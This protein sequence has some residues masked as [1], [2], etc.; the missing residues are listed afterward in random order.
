[1]SVTKGVG[2]RQFSDEF[3]RLVVSEVCS[4]ESVASVSKR[5]RVEGK[6]IRLWLSDGRYS[7]ACDENTVLHSARD[8][9]SSSFLPVEMMADA[10]PLSAETVSAEKICVR[11]QGG[12]SVEFPTRMD[13]SAL[14]YVLRGLVS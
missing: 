2:R 12:A 1:M 3:K 13:C 9:V 6:S 8:R 7:S 10:L 5:H 14:L 11:L 4:G